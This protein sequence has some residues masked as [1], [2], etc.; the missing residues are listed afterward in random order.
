MFGGGN[1][2]MLGGIPPGPGGMFGGGNGGMLGGRLD[3][4]VYIVR[5]VY[6]ARYAVGGREESGS[7]R[8]PR[9]MNGGIIPGMPDRN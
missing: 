7:I 6:V 9:P 1:G 5:D 8:P 3:G 4:A 2:G